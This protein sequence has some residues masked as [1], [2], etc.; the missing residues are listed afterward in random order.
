MNTQECYTEVAPRFLHYPIPSVYDR[1]TYNQAGKSWK[2]CF[3][4]MDD[5]GNAVPVSP[6]TYHYEGY[7][8]YLAPDY[9][10][11]TPVG[12]PYKYVMYYPMPH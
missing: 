11:A 3:C 2:H 9:D 1:R 7:K 5:F 4:V 6:F 8:P 10:H 12:Q